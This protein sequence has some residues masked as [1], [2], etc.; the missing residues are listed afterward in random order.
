MRGSALNTRTDF[1]RRFIERVTLRKRKYR[2]ISRC[3]GDSG[4]AGEERV[5]GVTQFHS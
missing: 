5:V 3:G 2:F 4:V 1:I